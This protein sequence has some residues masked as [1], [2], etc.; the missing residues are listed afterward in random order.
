[1]TLPRLT[2]GKLNAYKVGDWRR[3]EVVLK[4]LAL[5]APAASGVM[6]EESITLRNEILEGLWSGKFAN[7]YRWPDLKASTLDGRQDP[8][9]P[10]LIDT[11]SYASGIKLISMGPGVYGVGVPKSLKHPKATKDGTRSPLWLIGMTHEMPV[12]SHLPKREF[13]APQYYKS[14]T[15]LYAKLLAVIRTSLGGVQ[16]RSLRSSL[17]S[18]FGR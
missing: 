15:R 7:E 10:Q 8:D 13:W 3:A 6:Y 2:G 11:G 1:M 18:R 12:T 17:A 5:V 16:A 14:R 4:R 9:N